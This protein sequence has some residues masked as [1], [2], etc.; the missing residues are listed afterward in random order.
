MISDYTKY[1]VLE[2]IPGA[3]IWGSLIL[4][5]V[6]SFT[7]PLW[8]IY[9]IIVFDIYW[10]F[11]VVYF[12]L[13]LTHSLFRFKKDNA[14]DWLAK[15]NDEKPNWQ[16]YY[17]CIFMPVYNEDESVVRAS[18]DSLISSS[19]PADKMIVVLAGEERKVE[20]FTPIAEK[21][22]QE[23]GS[24]F[25]KFLVTV[26]P[27]DLPD[28]IPGKGSNIHY[29]GHKIR[30]WVDEQAIPYENIIVSSFDVDTIV[31]HHYF[32]CLTHTYLSQEDPTRASYQP[33]PLYN[34][35][36][37]ESPSVLRIMAFGTTFWL[38]TE[39]PRTDRM[40][41]FS[42]H[43]LSFK[44]LVDVNFWE[45]RIVS[46]DS[47]IYWQCFLHYDG[48]YRTVP[49]YLPVSMD[50]A[51][52]DTWWQ[53]IKNIYKQQRRWAWGVEH[54]PYL[55]WHFAKNSRIPLTKR[56]KHLFH[57][58]E[59]KFSWGM[60][61]IMILIFGR[62]PLWVAG[63]EV[64]QTVLFQNTPHILEW[65]MF[66]A[67]FGIVISMTYSLLLLPARPH[68]MKSYPFVYMLLQWILLPI[69]LIAVSAIPSIEAQTRMM[70]GKYLGFQVS[71]K[72]RKILGVETDTVSV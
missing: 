38:L 59:G 52:G 67:M 47:R 71:D 23:Y 58:I 20:H 26:H 65:L 9:F 44:A 60:T 48:N 1:R 22:E 55:I 7:K 50:T 64:R 62:L 40:V 54:T 61:A 49:L 42:S 4:L 39:L 3:L 19:Y 33:V 10:V 13:Y 68:A 51:R 11:R 63:E 12:S 24:R 6:L 32:S 70:F 28:E 66:L 8:V 41:T 34:N 18:L 15:L 37:W 25:F 17:Q 57:Q 35:N 14:I 36:M 45:K 31:H 21:L 53:S 69:S 5:T 29:A 27:Q 16:E 43:S 30:E 56:I 2:V 72:K 46:E